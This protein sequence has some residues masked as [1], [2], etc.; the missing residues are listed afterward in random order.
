[1]DVGRPHA[2]IVND[3]D[4]DVL[5]VLATANT[6]MNARQIWRLAGHG[7][8]KG[9]RTAAQRLDRLGVV[10]A[11]RVGAGDIY[12][13]N[14]EHLAAAAIRSLA[15]LRAAL[16]DRIRRAIGDW[17][18]APAH[19]SMFGSAARADG[20]SGSDIDLLVVRPDAVRPDDEPWR[21]QVDDLSSQILRWTGNHAGVL[22][23]SERE[24]RAAGRRA[25]RSPLAG[26]RR[27]AID[28]AGKSLHQVM[29]NPR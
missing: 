13:L 20:D 28:I 21:R 1:M 10:T 27:D 9:I 17:E 6:P 25:G 19:V 29:R 22:E 14:D 18:R 12:A 15:G 4:A 2:V 3:L 8:E 23:L 5:R 26:V 11:S 24:V 7:S 16:I